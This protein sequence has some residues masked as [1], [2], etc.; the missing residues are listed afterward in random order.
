MKAEDL[1]PLRSTCEALK[2][3]GWDTPTFFSW[4]N[5]LRF[6]D[7]PPIG[8]L[9]HGPKRT[10]DF[11]IAWAPTAAELM[12]ALPDCHLFKSPAGRP[13]IAGY[14]YLTKVKYEGQPR[15]RAEY[16]DCGGISLAHVAHD[17][18]AE[19]LAQLWLK[20]KA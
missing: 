9:E 4:N 8:Q 19:A 2:A 5:E 7:K 16:V 1:V 6:D 11:F 10:P 14:L 13:T 12:E 17:N 3:A 18:P 15:Y 20:V